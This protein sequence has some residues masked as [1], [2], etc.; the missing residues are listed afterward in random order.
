MRALSP[1]FELLLSGLRNHFS[2]P[3]CSRAKDV[4]M[5]AKLPV[6]FFSTRSPVVDLF[7]GQLDYADHLR[8]DAEVVLYFFYAPWCGQSIAAREEIERVAS[9]LSEQVTREYVNLKHDLI[10]F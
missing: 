9:R 7:R 4:T 2:F 3:S 6:N 5:P 10:G 1:L 8:Q